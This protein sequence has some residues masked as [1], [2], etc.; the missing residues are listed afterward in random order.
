MEN[1][2]MASD[3]TIVDY[4]AFIGLDWGSEKH[5]VAFQAANSKQIE[6]YTLK[7]TPEDLHGWL[8]KLRD[9]FGG[10]PVAISVTEHLKAATKEHL[11][12]G[13]SDS[14]QSVS[15]RSSQRIKTIEI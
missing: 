11:K 3:A 1:T 6:I 10:R 2:K 9:K 14:R 12:T 8:F 7:Q 13:H 5:S 4:A 15:N